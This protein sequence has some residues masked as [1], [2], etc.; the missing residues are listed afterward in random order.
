MRHDGARTVIQ[1]SR[2]LIDVSTRSSA[3]NPL[4]RA[5]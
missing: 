4:K 3:R 5:A 1:V 2:V